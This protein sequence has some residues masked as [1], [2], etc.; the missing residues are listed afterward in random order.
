MWIYQMPVLIMYCLFIREYGI[1]R[2]G[3]LK[4]YRQMKAYHKLYPRSSLTIVGTSIA[5]FLT[6][7]MCLPNKDILP[8]CGGISEPSISIVLGLEFNFKSISSIL[9][10]QDCNCTLRMI[11]SRGRRCH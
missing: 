2:D 9:F 1:A 11:S 5:T 4:N 8:C 6:L 7:E 10:E 3:A